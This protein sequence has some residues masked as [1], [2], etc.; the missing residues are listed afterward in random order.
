MNTR[1]DWK[2]ATNDF[3][4]LQKDWKKIGATAFRDSQKLW[5]RFQ[6]ACNAFFNA[7]ADFDKQQ[8]K[9]L[10]DNVSIIARLLLI[11]NNALAK[12]VENFF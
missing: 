5:T 12:M 3:I 8:N 7:K 2:D 1:T 9:I 6:N 4:Q 11:L 10:E